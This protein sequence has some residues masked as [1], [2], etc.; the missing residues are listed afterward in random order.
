MTSE[1]NAHEDS[2]HTLVARRRDAMLRAG[3]DAMV[4]ARA[5]RSRRRGLFAGGLLIAACLLSAKLWSDGRAAKEQRALPAIDFAIVVTPAHPIRVEIVR[6]DTQT[7][8][9]RISDEQLVGALREAGTCAT[10]VCERLP[11]VDRLWVL[12]CDTTQSLV[13]PFLV[14]KRAQR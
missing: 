5:A 13:A 1:M 10:L 12:A 6:A 9:Q 4:N 8:V 3:T 11:T 7:R 2:L 14:E